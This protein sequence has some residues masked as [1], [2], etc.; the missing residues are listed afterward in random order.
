MAE[1]KNTFLKGKM[2]Q[3]VDPRIIAN[4]EYREARNLSI[5]RSES[6]TVGEFE[7]I[8]GN[9]VLSNL[10]AASVGAPA[11][12]E[13]IGQIIDQNN[14]VGYFLATDWGPTAIE[15]RAPNTAKCYIVKINLAVAAAPV[16]LV[17]GFFLNFNKNFR[18]TGINLL[19][20]QL[21]WTDNLNQ[22]RKINITEAIENFPHYT[23]EDQI[24]VAK[25]APFEPILVMDRVN[26]VITSPST[27]VSTATIIINDDADYAL[28]KVGDIVTDKNKITGQQITGLVT[29]I[30][31]PA[32]PT[33]ALTL[34]SAITVTN[35]TA[36]DFSRP[37]MTNKRNFEMANHSAGAVT[38]DTTSPGLGT[39][40]KIGP[41]GANNDTGNFIY[42]GKNGIPRIGDLVSG[43]G[44]S[45]DTRIKTVNVVNQ[46]RDPT[47]TDPDSFAIYQTISFTLN[48]TTTI[49]SGDTI[50]VSDNPDYDG[51]WQGDEKLLEDKFIRF[52]YRFK[53]EDNE[54]SLIAPFSQVMFIPKQYSQFGGGAFSDEQDMDNAYKS[55]IVTWFENNINNILLK[56]PIPENITTVAGLI[57]SL[58]IS[59]IDILYKESDAIAVKVLET[60]NLVESTLVVSSISFNDAIHGNSSTSFIDYNYSSTKPYKTLP[61]DQI[62]RVSDKVPIRA[63]AQEIIGNR[64][65]YANYLDRHTSP[66]SIAFSAFATN[67][68]TDFDNYT[69]FPKHQLKQ[70]RTYQVGF[71]LSDRYGRQSDVI[72]SSYDNEINKPGSTVFNPYNDLSTQQQSPILDWLGDA[73]SL[74]LFETIN[75][76]ASTTT[77]SPGVYSSTN[78]LGWYSYR[79]VVKQTE[80]EY[81]NVYLPGFVNGYPV[82]GT[83]NAER[84]TSFFTTVIGDNIN[85]IP[86]D[87]SEVGPNDRDFTS[88]ENIMIRV[89]NP[90]INNKV[91]AGFTY[92][93]P[94]NAQYYPGNIEQE[95]IQ[96][97]TVR[98]LE[99]QAIP[100]KANAAEGEYGSSGFVQTYNYDSAGQVESI[101]EVSE[102]TGS[103]PWG[104]TGPDATFYNGDSNPFIIKGNQSQNKN[105][106][107]GAYVTTVSVNTIPPA[108]TVLSMVPFLSI[109][110]TKP[111]ESIL[112]IFWETSLSGKLTTLNS[113]VG[114]QA[115]GLVSSNFQPASFPESATE[116]DL[117]GFG[118]NYL[119][120]NGQTA[121]AALITLN[122][123]T[124]KDSNDNPLSSALFLITKNAAQTAFE[125]NPASPYFFYSAAIKSSPNTGIFNITTNV[126]YSTE[127]AVDIVLPGITLA[128]SAPYINTFTQ[129]TPTAAVGNIITLGIYGRN[130]SANTTD[131]T[132]E[133][134]WS[135]DSI[136]PVESPA[137]IQINSTTGE[138]SNNAVLTN[139]TFYSVGVKATDANGN[140]LVSPVKLVQFQIGAATTNRVN[141]ALCQGWKTTNFTGCEQSN[142]NNGRLQVQ[143]YTN[144]SLSPSASNETVYNSGSTG[145]SV[146]YGLGSAYTSAETYNVLA[147]NPSS[148]GDFST[149]IHTTGSLEQGT[150]Y[151]T[152]T[153]VNAG[154]SGVDDDVVT[155]TIQ[156]KGSGGWVQAVDTN[157][158]EV[159]NVTLQVAA[160]SSVDSKHVFDVAGEYRV[161]TTDITGG[162]CS[163]SQNNTSMRVNFGD[164]NYSSCFASP[165]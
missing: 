115:S 117:I 137:K 133:L 37:T 63:L 161:L 136:S 108:Q 31:K 8:L 155:F 73:L 17:E 26:A 30:G 86:R 89:N 80:Q 25:Y 24:S 118:F 62:T 106:P 150:L 164:E 41:G 4:G 85:K 153:L 157:S 14:N 1:I 88:S 143:F 35:G 83:Q 107:I 141:K 93:K 45:S 102:E 147:R 78:P 105:N 33:R 27:A 98:D 64:V 158:V 95:I 58:K 81:Y 140:G 28:V 10:T 67:K 146:T 84:D 160:N 29:V 7:N 42:G 16:I 65:A 48:K 76:V 104:V 109:A 123:F 66:T 77:G 101:T 116:D 100:F 18:V 43:N 70:D 125:I 52:S 142:P 132:T 46:Y 57:S 44:I 49:S 113:L 12:T 72:L 122:S 128:N 50:S 60:I 53:F 129:P 54:Y 151:I 5:S 23:N 61:T 51:S 91:I 69:Q 96:I 22:P 32:S 36:I 34:S 126:T 149:D 130:G 162:M 127:N 68:S 120:G 21:F 119:K 47:G 87:L 114:S 71:V 6:S 165:A 112:D 9:T 38:L 124:V 75:P 159:R 20:N 40:Y 156:F 97:G 138:L 2:N 152:P 148:Q 13:I 139:A 145:S 92:S 154:G 55:T 15:T 111:V 56:I 131:N 103:I 110:E 3:D 74:T 19:E 135:I 121:S 79:I 11:D 99:I 82:V 134:S 94:Y 39:I 90:R 163:L 144:S 59:E